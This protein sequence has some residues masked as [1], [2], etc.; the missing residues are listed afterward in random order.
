MR[1]ALRDA[2]P[3]TQ[4]YF[5]IGGIVKRILNFGAPAPIDVEILGHDL[6]AGADY[7]KQVLARL[8]ALDD[9]D[10]KPLA[11]RRADHAR[12]ELPAS[13]TS[14]VDR[15]EGGRRSG[16]PSSRSRRRC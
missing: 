13:S 5:F 12:G 7:A 1:G 8:R 2:L 14:I 6:D 11:D 4:V 15:A 10:G 16:C 9:K 3:G